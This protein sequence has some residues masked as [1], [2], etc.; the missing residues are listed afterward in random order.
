VYCRRVV[1]TTGGGVR[2]GVGG[3]CSRRRL[4][5]DGSLHAGRQDGLLARE[6][7]EAPHTHNGRTT[8][9]ITSRAAQQSCSEHNVARTSCCTLTSSRS[10]RRS[11]SRTRS[12]PRPRSTRSSGC[13]YRSRK[14]GHR[15]ERVP[16]KKIKGMYTN[17]HVTVCL[18]GVHPTPSQPRWKPGPCTAGVPVDQCWRD[19]A[20][21]LG[22]RTPCRS[23]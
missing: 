21:T 22:G 4:L 6:F 14:G 3:G 9:S 13:T 10:S 19:L 12:A 8:C 16:D 1:D 23:S 5:C 11:R 2:C 15:D 18:D 7:A 20:R 17:K